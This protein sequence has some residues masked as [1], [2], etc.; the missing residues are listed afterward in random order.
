[1][2][3]LMFVSLLSPIIRLFPKS[4]VDIGGKA[5]WLSP[6]LALPVVLVIYVVIEKIMKKAAPGEGLADMII[7]AIGKT[8]GKGVLV[9]ITLWLIFYT[10][11]VIKSGAERLISSI[12]PNGQTGLFTV[13]I[14][15]IGIWIAVGDINGI[16]RLAELM[17]KIIGIVLTLIII[18][19]IFD[20]K[21]DNI[22]PI[23]IYDIGDIAFGALPII[24]VLSI[25]T[26]TAFLDGYTKKDNINKKGIVIV[27]TI[28]ITAI[29][30]ITVGTMG[31]KLIESLQ[32]NFFIMI[33]D[34]KIL[35]VIERIEAIVI[36]MWVATDLVY[37]AMLLKICGEITVTI[38]GKEKIKIFSSVSGIL[39]FI[40]ANLIIN[41]AFELHYLSGIV[42]PIINILIV[43]LLLPLILVAGEKIRKKGKKR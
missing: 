33:R 13:S 38:T 6:L 3:S 9:L 24:N 43:L 23:T 20:I 41:N 37:V 42:V 16:G 18:V 8:A 5:V 36:A 30:L 21:A 19:G 35:G 14:T 17:A 26:Y 1:M 11:F 15:I 34:M 2:K 39:A 28:I 12:Y 29:I 22:L 4:S 31:T 40:I 32:H 25:G 7:K 27:L 10:G